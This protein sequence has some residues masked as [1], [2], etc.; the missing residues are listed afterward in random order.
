MH[1]HFSAQQLS[2]PSLAEAER[3]IKSCVRHG[4][5][6]QT[7]PTYVL[8][9]DENLFEHIRHERFSLLVAGGIGEGGQIGIDG[10]LGLRET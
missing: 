10:V 7:C 6:P 4:F 2:D 5:C 1:T 3:I 9:G 8:L